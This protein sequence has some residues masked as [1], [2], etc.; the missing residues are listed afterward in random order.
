MA[1]T[2]MDIERYVEMASEIKSLPKR[3]LYLSYDVEADVAYI[4]FYN[5]A[6][7]ADDSEL[8]DDDVIVR[9]DEQ[10]EIIGLTILHVSSRGLKSEQRK[11]STTKKGAFSEILTTRTRIVR[12]GEFKNQRP[13][14]RHR[15]TRQ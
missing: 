5:P 15:R 2:S 11:Q 14:S 6:K 1:L 3:D 7:P 9:Y 12:V 10:Q 4:N 8:T 13:I